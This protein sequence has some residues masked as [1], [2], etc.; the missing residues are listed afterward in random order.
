MALSRERCTG[1]AKIETLQLVQ[2]FASTALDSV[3]PENKAD[4][5]KIASL[6]VVEKGARR[7]QA[8]H[9]NKIIWRLVLA[10]FLHHMGKLLGG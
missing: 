4:L 3:L 1:G 5:Q 6:A 7:Y 2:L 8:L 10:R 9:G